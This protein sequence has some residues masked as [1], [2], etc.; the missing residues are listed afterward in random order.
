M[1]V[2]FLRLGM[3]PLKSY[4]GVL[5]YLKQTINMRRL[6]RFAPLIATSTYTFAE[7]P[8][9]NEK[10]RGVYENKIR[11]FAPME[12]IFET[13]ASEKKGKDIYM[14]KTD[15]F[16]A[17]SPYNF[18]PKKDQDFFETYDSIIFKMIDAN[19]DG[20]VSYSEFIFFIVLLSIDDSF[21][22]DFIED[23]NGF[24]NREQ[25]SRMCNEARLNSPHVKNLLSVHGMIDPRSASFNEE[26]FLSNTRMLAKYL[27]KAT[28]HITADDLF[29]CRDL[30]AEEICFYQFHKFEIDEDQTIS[31]Q[32]FAKSIIACMDSKRI[33][34]HVRRAEEITVQGRVSFGEFFAFQQLLSESKK[35][36]ARLIIETQNSKALSL[37][38][39]VRIFLAACH[40]H[41]YLKEHGLTV[42]PIQVE[43]FLKLLDQNDNGF[44]EPEEFFDI[45]ASKS[46][47]GLGKTTTPT[48]EKTVQY[49]KDTVHHFLVSLGLDQFVNFPK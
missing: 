8:P 36:E 33:D 12:K 10:V 13:F 4:G 6:L 41:R 15:F 27:F 2:S 7:P 46:N 29:N 22:L 17:L 25:F 20:L 1:S 42:S 24:I 35:L 37:R 47:Y 40:E 44:L 38:K 23:H 11:Q 43:V 9:F 34:I 39:L 31:A 3:L 28:K 16:E 19:K 14:T 48:F 21:I 32:D 45:I 49:I 18:S 5:R 26:S 30:V